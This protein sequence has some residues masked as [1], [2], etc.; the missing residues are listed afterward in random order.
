MNNVLI[1]PIYDFET[2]RRDLVSSN[3]YST[4]EME[5][6]VIAD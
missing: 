6:K 4:D 5:Y 3:S 2:L 1:S